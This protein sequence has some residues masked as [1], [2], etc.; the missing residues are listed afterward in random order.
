VFVDEL[1]TVGRSRTSGVGG[2]SG[3][4]DER[5]QT[6]NQILTEIDGFGSATNVIVIGATNRPDVLDEALL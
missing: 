4:N 2:F 5:E 1:D 6:L 3:G